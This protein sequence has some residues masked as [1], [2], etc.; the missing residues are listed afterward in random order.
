[1]QMENHLRNKKVLFFSPVF[2]D[3][4]IL[5]QEEMRKLGMVVDFFPDRPY[6]RLY[7]ILHTFF[8]F[9]VDY[10]ERFFLK[11]V[12]KKIYGNSYDFLFVIKGTTFT[13]SFLNKLYGS[14]K[15][16]K[17]I[18]HQWDS[19]KSHNYLPILSQFDIAYTF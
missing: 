11:Q 4:H 17:R 1:M 2:Y 14:I 10:Y 9:L 8:P 13:S 19:I 6:N 18:L 15:V 16:Q 7:N 3:Y 12:I 5:I